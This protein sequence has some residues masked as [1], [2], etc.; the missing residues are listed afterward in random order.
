M[1][2]CTGGCNT[3]VICVCRSLTELC[4]NWSAHSSSHSCQ[5]FNQGCFLVLPPSFLPLAHP[6]TSPWPSPLAS[7]PH[8]TVQS[9]VSLSLF[10]STSMHFLHILIFGPVVCSSQHLFSTPAKLAD[11]IHCSTP[12]FTVHPKYTHI[13]YRPS[14]LSIIFTH[15]LAFF[16]LVHFCYAVYYM[17]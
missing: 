13:S 11:S 17:V 1:C 4:I 6:C 3:Y 15:L 16:C 2:V 8:T 10:A 5:T 12:W 9:G 7:H 14:S